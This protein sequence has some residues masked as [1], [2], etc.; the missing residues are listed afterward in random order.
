MCVAHFGG[1]GTSDVVVP[2]RAA[3]HAAAAD[4]KG[5]VPRTNFGALSFEIRRSARGPKAALPDS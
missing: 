5:R 2:N 4:L 3:Q 1:A